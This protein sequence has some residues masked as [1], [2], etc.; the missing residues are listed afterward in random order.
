VPAG[1]VTAEFIERLG[2]PCANATVDRTPASTGD[3]EFNN[4]VG[5]VKFAR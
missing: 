2:R 3:Q 5:D 4:P 1:I